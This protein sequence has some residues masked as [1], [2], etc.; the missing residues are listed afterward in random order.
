[1]DTDTFAELLVSRPKYKGVFI[2][3]V[4]EGA[5]KSKYK[6]GEIN[7][8]QYKIPAD[9]FRD[10]PY[11]IESKLCHAIKL[12]LTEYARVLG[13]YKDRFIIT[14]NI[15]K[16]VEISDFITNAYTLMGKNNKKELLIAESN[17]DMINL[18][19]ECMSILVKRANESA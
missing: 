4:T 2:A 9:T 3:M 5:K 11:I 7:A 10:I 17:T 16:Y 8:N 18:I 13:E 19:E 14:N 1:M 12:V 15:Q 6:I